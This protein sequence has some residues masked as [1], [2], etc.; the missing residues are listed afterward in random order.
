M[1]PLCVLIA[2]LVCGVVATGTRVQGQQAAPRVDHLNLELFEQIPAQYLTAASNL[3]L[4]FV[5]RS[6]GANINSGLNC[7]AQPYATAPSYCKQWQHAAP[8]FS[9]PE[10]PWTGS[11]PRDRW[12]FGAWPGTG[13]P[14]EISCGGAETSY[15]YEQLNCFIRHID[16]NPAAYDVVAFQF[17]YLEVMEHS[18][19]TDPATG[20]FGSN[21][22]PGK[23]TVADLAALRS[24]HPNIRFVLMTSSLARSIGTVQARDFNAGLR[25]Y[26]QANGW[27]L[28]DFAAFISHSPNGQPCFDNRDGVP[29]IINGQVRENY[30]NDGLDLPAICQ[31][32]TGEVDGGHLGPTAGMIRAGKAWWIMMARLAGWTPGA[33]GTPTAPRNLRIVG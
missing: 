8:E 18:D 17:S 11:F 10:N 25:N 19:I 14:P 24:R 33:V 4:L 32:Y 5:N 26:A 30:P 16:A 31:H 3:R 1:R 7:L 6:V 9:V 23:H 12:Q 22:F 13:I 21:P 15:W 29:Y 20:F 27:P 28:Y 2:T